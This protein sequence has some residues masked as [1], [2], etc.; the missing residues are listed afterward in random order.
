MVGKKKNIG[1]GE[2]S[3]SGT[4]EF[5]VSNNMYDV[6]QEEL[7]VVEQDE[8]VLDSTLSNV[9]H[10]SKHKCKPGIKGKT[11]VGMSL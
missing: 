10:K 8:Q 7:Y 2:P 4:M 9:R 1:Y 6:L 11:C 3:S 5:S